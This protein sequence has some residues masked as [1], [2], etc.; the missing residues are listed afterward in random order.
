MRLRI[1]GH[2][3]HPALVHFPL[4]L[5]FSGVFWD[6]IGWWQPDP[7]W[8]QMAYWCFALG[9]AASLP[10]VMTG[11][12]DYLGL[13]PE[14]PG[15]DVAATHM[16]LMVSATVAFGGSWMLRA[17]SGSTVAPSR[18]ALA[19]A[20]L[21]ALLL[22]AGGWLGGTLVYRHGIGRAERDG[23]SAIVRQQR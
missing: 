12:M 20:F 9:L 11:F 1:A 22:S 13:E 6:F 8:W 14:A 19:L 4:A 17:L 15:I 18:S 7:L 10:S 16:M 23:A 2:P 21:G 3:V 5:W